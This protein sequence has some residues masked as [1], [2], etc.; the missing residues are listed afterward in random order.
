MLGH[1]DTPHLKSRQ[2]PVDHS[3]I[4]E[5]PAIALLIVKLGGWQAICDED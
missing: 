2:N 4:V 5:F 1:A 3:E